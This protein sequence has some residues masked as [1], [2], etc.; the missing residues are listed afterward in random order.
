[1][2]FFAHHGFYEEERKG[3]NEFFL[4]VEIRIQK[5]ENYKDDIDKTINY[6]TIYSICK[7]EMNNTKQLLE[8]VVELIL[9]R[10]QKQWPEALGA[11]VEIRKLAPQLGGKV[12]Y[13]A[14][15]MEF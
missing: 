8:T 9:E 1:M 14:V 4:D 6:E 7:E 11:K 13:S 3:G 2:Y 12:K 15:K 5:A 10:I